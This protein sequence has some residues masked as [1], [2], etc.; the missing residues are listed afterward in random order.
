MGREL[1]LRFTGLFFTLGAGVG[2][3]GVGVTLTCLNRSDGEALGVT[4]YVI[5]GV[6]FGV[7]SGVADGETEV[8]WGGASDLADVAMGVAVVPVV[9]VSFAQVDR[10]S[11]GFSLSSFPLVRIIKKM[12]KKMTTTANTA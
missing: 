6:A 3:A 5:F 11:A 9:A 8:I 10:R 2:G 1:G 4:R 12:P 7:A